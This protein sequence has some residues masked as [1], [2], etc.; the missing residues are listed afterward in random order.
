[1]EL[2]V[3]PGRKKESKIIYDFV[4]LWLVF[5]KTVDLDK[6]VFSIHKTTPT[7]TSTLYSYFSSPNSLFQ[8]SGVKRHKISQIDMGVFSK[9]KIQIFC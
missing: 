4:C 5:H 6:K 3:T 7:Y 8:V 9:Y 1:M 2:K